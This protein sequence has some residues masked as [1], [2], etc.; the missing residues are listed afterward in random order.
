M[1]NDTSVFTAGQSDSRPPHSQSMTSVKYTRHEICTRSKNSLTESPHHIFLTVTYCICI[2]LH[3]NFRTCGPV[4]RVKG[5]RSEPSDGN[6][7]F[8]T[9]SGLKVCCKEREQ[10]MGT[11][12]SQD[13]NTLHLI[14]TVDSVR[15][16]VK[17]NTCSTS[18]TLI[19]PTVS[20][21]FFPT[22]R[23]H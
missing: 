4:Q 10:M 9:P 12:E 2:F 3:I 11:S 17:G 18:N 23:F 22:L 8:H 6:V 14:H 7:P 21:K 5:W 13:M 20:R 1:R 16:G 15:D 19:P